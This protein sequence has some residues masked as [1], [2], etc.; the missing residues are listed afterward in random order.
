M[1]QRLVLEQREVVRRVVGDDRDAG[2]EQRAQR[3]DDSPMTSAAGRPCARACAVVMPWTAV[4][5]AGISMP[6]SAIQS[7]ARTTVPEASSSPTCAVTMRSVVDVDAGRLEVEHADDAVHGGRL[8]EGE[9]LGLPGAMPLTV[10]AASDIAPPGAP[11]GAA[12]VD[13]GGCPFPESR[14]RRSSTRSPS[15]GARSRSLGGTTA[16]WVYGPEDA[17]T[18]VVA[19]HGFRGEHHGLEPVVAHL[20]ASASSRPTC[21]ASARRRRCP[22]ARHDIDAYAD[23]LRGLRRGRRA[24]RRDPRPLVRL[25]RRRGGRRRRARRRRA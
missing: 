23:W 2:S 6:G 8:E 10:W 19:V 21:P 15:S 20:P 9:R 25:D 1:T 18:T 11:R 4:A 24:G 22:A 16:Y 5:P 13:S 14:T 7:R 17:E 3:G 12:L